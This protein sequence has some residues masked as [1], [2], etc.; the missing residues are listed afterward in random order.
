[1]RKTVL[2]LGI[3]SSL[4]FG[5]SNEELLQEI[6]LLKKEL[7]EVKTTQNSIV[8]E[9]AQDAY[10]DG[11]EYESFSSMGG[12]ASKVYYSKDAL[13]IGGYGEYKYTKYIDYKNYADATANE[14]RNKGE[15][16]IVRFVPYFGFKFS[17]SIIM[18][19]EIEF[20]DGGSRSDGEKN[21]KYA[22]VEFSYLDFLIDKA[23]AIRAGHILVPM[24]LIN[25]NHEPVSYLS[26]DR[27]AVETYIIPSTWHTNGVLAH[28]KIDNLEYYAGVIVSPDAGGFTEGRFIQQGRTGA[29]VFS[30]DFSFV[31]RLSY[32]L[33]DG[34]NIGG[35]F[36]YGNSSAAKESKPGDTTGVNSNA[37]ITITMAELHA[38]YKKEG[39][40]IQAISTFGGLGGDVA[41][42]GSDISQELSKSVNGEY[43]NVGYDVLPWFAKS[44]QTLYAFAE[45]ER[46]DM[47]ASGDTT[48]VDN[49]RFYEYTAGLSYFPDPK[50]TIKADYKIR[51]YASGAK[52]ADEN[53]FALAIGFIF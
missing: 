2:G 46:L 42:L 30:D 4:V 21:Y 24:G 32:D 22:I 6:T 17:D 48:Y 47:D 7:Q 14:T 5:M 50:V 28:G 52:L 33:L 25:L 35:S 34:L 18:N 31:T 10:L 44:S 16:N 38:S 29:R 27:P 8:D 13:S 40:N 37:K 43:L 1:M 39:W 15:S 19:T 23:F 3:C 12:A 26:T 45:V 20:E 36:L 41:Q 51:D 53:S 11:N 9:M 49:N